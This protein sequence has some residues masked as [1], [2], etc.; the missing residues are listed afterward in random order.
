MARNHIPEMMRAPRTLFESKTGHVYAESFFDGT[1]RWCYIRASRDGKKR[2]EDETIVISQDELLQIAV[3]ITSDA[4]RCQKAKDNE[5]Y[6]DEV[7][8]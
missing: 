6:Y 3:A 2:P 4:N 1:S 7:D 8:F 5:R